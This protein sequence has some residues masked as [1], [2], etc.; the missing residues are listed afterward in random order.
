MSVSE[1]LPNLRLYSDGTCSAAISS[2][3]VAVAGSNTVTVSALTLNATTSI[4]AR[5]ADLAG[6]TSPCTYLTSYTHAN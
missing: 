5:A 2:S 1:A 6:N 4:Y 3:V